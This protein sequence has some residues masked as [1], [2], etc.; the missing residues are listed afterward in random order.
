LR[1]GSDGNEA[2]EARPRISRVLGELALIFLGIT[3]ALWFDNANQARKQQ[4]LETQILHEMSA[5]LIRD[6]ADLHINL[7][8]GDSAL[9]SIDT[10]LARLAGSAKYSD[11]LA[12]RFGW[13]SRFFRFFNNPAAYEHLRSAGLDVIS[14]DTLRQSVISYYDS[15]V[16][17]LRW[18]EE[19]VV[20][21]NWES[22]LLP[23]MM[24]KFEFEGS[25]M[26]AIPRDYTALRTDVEYQT[27]LKVTATLM[28]NQV[29]LTSRTLD[30]AERLIADIG[31]EL[32]DR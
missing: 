14:N 9:A 20:L 2:W 13:S 30:E 1:R 3:A 22:Y 24:T 8:L 4:Q 16:P 18:V 6:T 19:S 7:V 11:E 29:D 26:P 25:W 17:T 31:G 15:W 23:H 28:R 27:A 12:G 21:R 32:Q 5:G 10:V